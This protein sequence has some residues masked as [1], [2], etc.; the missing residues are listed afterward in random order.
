MAAASSASVMSSGLT[1]L[2]MSWILP[3]A[4]V[5]VVKGQTVRSGGHG[6]FA[7]LGWGHNRLVARILRSDS[8]AL[9]RGCPRQDST[10]GLLLRREEALG[11]TRREACPVGV[12]PTLDT[13]Y[14]L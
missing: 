1:R 13:Y 14:A 5:A 7:S 9:V 8:F 4:A 6:C 12:P 2:M 3:D 11:C 10:C